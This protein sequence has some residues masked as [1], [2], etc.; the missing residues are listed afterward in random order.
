VDEWRLTVDVSDQP[1]ELQELLRGVELR[2]GEG[3]PEKVALVESFGV[4]YDVYCMFGFV[5]VIC[6]S[7]R[8]LL[9]Y[10][11]GAIHDLDDVR[12]GRHDLTLRNVDGRRSLARKASAS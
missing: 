9:L 6:E 12:I 7:G 4:G 11:D 10:T 3:R 1:G 5:K 8:K 2:V